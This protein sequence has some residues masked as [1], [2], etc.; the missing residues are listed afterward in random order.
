MPA[1]AAAWH[2]S[3]VVSFDVAVE[4]TNVLVAQL[5]RRADQSGADPRDEIRAARERLVALDSDDAAAVAALTEDLVARITM[6]A[7]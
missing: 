1:K 4:L 5:M 7:S 2:T 3:D 6:V